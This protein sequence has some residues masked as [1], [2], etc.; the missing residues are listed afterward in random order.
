M[1][2]WLLDKLPDGLLAHPAE[3]FL[4][5]LCAMTGISTLVGL[6]QPAVV[7]R[8]LPLPIYV[9]WGTSLIT[10]AFAY[11]VGLASIRF[12]ANGSYVVTRASWYRLGLRLLASASLIFAGCIVTVSGL[13]FNVAPL[14]L[15]AVMCW[16]RLLV[17]GG[18]P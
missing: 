8:L 2:L 14:L 15:F 18:R 11:A 3:W 10:G 7:E 9:L 6:T 4:A 12:T 17:L 1:R 13:G 16:I 5:T